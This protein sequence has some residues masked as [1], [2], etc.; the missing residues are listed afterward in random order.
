M[1][2][3]FFALFAFLTAF[4]GMAQNDQYTITGRVDRGT[5][6]K[7]FLMDQTKD[8]LSKEAILDSSDVVLRE[9]KFSGHIASPVPAVV[10]TKDPKD[11]TNMVPVAL[12]IAEPG[13]ITVK[14]LGV[15]EGSPLNDTLAHIIVYANESV[16]TLPNKTSE[17][18][19]A[20]FQQYLKDLFLRHTN[21]PVGLRVMGSYMN[22]DSEKYRLY[23][24][25]GPM[26]QKFF[27]NDKDKW[28]KSYAT[29]EGGMMVDFQNADGSQRLS[30]FVGKGKYTLVDFW[31]SWCR[32][33]KA[34]IPNI[35][36]VY[37]K[38]AGEQFQ[39]VGVDCWEKREAAEKTIEEMKI[40]YAQIF[41]V[42]IEQTSEYGISGIP[43]IILFG[44]DGRILRRNLRGEEIEKAVR[45][46]LGK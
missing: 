21:D 39:V 42:G 43:H 20:I 18:K 31:A 2:R 40:P 4:T 41:N 23:E 7:V 29:R 22:D 45:E 35:I 25:A 30:D 14:E 3:I 44:P 27:A 1:K 26:V 8:L 11:P 34:E 46:A 6:R 9:Y 12:L 28:M 17:E 10:A 5:I 16:A 19:H 15:S 13:E 33:C 32:P 37:V 38:Y 24:Q 36:Q